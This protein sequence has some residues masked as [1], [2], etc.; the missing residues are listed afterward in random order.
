M[1]LWAGLS[2]AERAA[3]IRSK[4][5]LAGFKVYHLRR[6]YLMNKIKMMK[7]K[8]TKMAPFK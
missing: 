8:A 4:F 1:E 5:K 6:V 2:M 3:K 7:V